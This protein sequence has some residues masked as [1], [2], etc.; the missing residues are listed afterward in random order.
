MTSPEPLPPEREQLYLS[1]ADEVIKETTSTAIKELGKEAVAEAEKL[2]QLDAE[3][4]Q[5]SK[6]AEEYARDHGLQEQF[7]KD[8]EAILGV[9]EAQK[10]VAAQKHKPSGDQ[11]PKL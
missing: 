10:R 6:G 2:T 5:V 9:D 11:P 8:I 7:M 3:A 1:R 4:P